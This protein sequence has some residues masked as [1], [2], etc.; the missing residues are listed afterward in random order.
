MSQE[1]TFG[2]SVFTLRESEQSTHPNGLG[3]L[4]NLLEVKAIVFSNH[5]LPLQNGGGEA[6]HAAVF[7]FELQAGMKS[8]IRL[9]KEDVEHTEVIPDNA[10][11][12]HCTNVLMFNLLTDPN[13]LSY[14]PG[15]NHYRCHR[16]GTEEG[17]CSK[18]GG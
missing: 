11:S 4:V 5:V 10:L 1:D 13:F 6:L 7:E 9:K 8:Q 3:V 12:K 18:A 14:N 15:H 17:F 2:A 16:C